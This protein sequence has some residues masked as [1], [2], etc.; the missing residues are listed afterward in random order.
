MIRILG[1]VNEFFFCFLFYEYKKLNGDL[2]L[3]NNE[4]FNSN[5]LSVYFTGNLTIIA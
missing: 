5:I 4:Y 1:I 2:F 3:D